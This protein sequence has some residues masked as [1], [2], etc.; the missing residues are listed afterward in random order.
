[1]PGQGVLLTNYELMTRDVPEFAEHEQPKF[2]LLVLDEAQR[3]KNRGSR[4]AETAR[5][6]KRRRA[7]ALT[8]TPIENRPDELSSL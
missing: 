2:D 4:T 6:I 5:G 1:M 7:W 8:G 3:I